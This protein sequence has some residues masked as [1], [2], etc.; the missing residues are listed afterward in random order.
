MDRCFDEVYEVSWQDV[1]SQQ[2][3]SEILRTI[4]DVPMVGQLGHFRTRQQVRERFSL[5]D[6]EDDARRHME[7]CWVCQHHKSG[8]DSLATRVSVLSWE[9]MLASH[10][11]GALETYSRADFIGILLEHGTPQ[12]SVWVGREVE[13]RDHGLDNIAISILQSEDHSLV[14]IEMYG[15]APSELWDA[16]VGAL[17]ER[18]GVS[19][20]CMIGFFHCWGNLRAGQDEDAM[21]QD[22]SAWLRIRYINRSSFW[23]AGIQILLEVVA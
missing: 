13:F 10:D 8:H 19:G 4:H 22:G 1:W 11:P 14:G 7:A 15:M 9:S 17:L 6:L 5:E 18:M 12:A 16:G 23:L 3:A 2:A 21:W 20:T